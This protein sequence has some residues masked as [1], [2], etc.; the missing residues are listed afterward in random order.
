[1][2]NN[3]LSE[4]DELIKQIKRELNDTP[5]IAKREMYST[6]AEVNNGWNEF[7]TNCRTNPGQLIG[8]PSVSVDMPSTSDGSR[9]DNRMQ[10]AKGIT[11][12]EKTSQSLHRASQ[13]AREAEGTNPMNLMDLMNLTE[14]NSP[15]SDSPTHS[16]I[17]LWATRCRSHSNSTC[18]F[19][20]SRNGNAHIDRTGYDLDTG[21]HW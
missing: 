4:G 3:F 1:M 2:L 16:L 21:R 9:F 19:P 8:G 18:H 14:V 11:I 13:A 20:S 15:N 7:K 6:F 5:F 17:K 10:L 12:L